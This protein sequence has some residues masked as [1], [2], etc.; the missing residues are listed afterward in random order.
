MLKNNG[1][2]ILYGIFVG[3]SLFWIVLNLL[4]F[5]TKFSSAREVEGLYF[6]NL[7]NLG[8]FYFWSIVLETSEKEKLTGSFFIDDDSLFK[9]NDILFL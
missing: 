9:V 2:S 7:T 4:K 6:Y 1:S 3:M 8:E 5:F